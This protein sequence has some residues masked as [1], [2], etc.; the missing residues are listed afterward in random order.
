MAASGAG[1]WEVV[2]NDFPSL[3]SSPSSPSLSSCP[4]LPLP[5]PSIDK[6]KKST[7]PERQKSD[8]EHHNH[9]H[10]HIDNNHDTNNK[11]CYIL[12]FIGFPRLCRR[13]NRTFWMFLLIFICF[14]YRFVDFGNF[15]SIILQENQRFCEFAGLHTVFFTCWSNFPEKSEGKKSDWQVALTT[16]QNPP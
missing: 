15:R 4:Y 6:Q 11:F 12:Y 3:C 2:Y 1:D 14:S 10:Q 16:F 7:D 5:C 13:D 9:H 8:L